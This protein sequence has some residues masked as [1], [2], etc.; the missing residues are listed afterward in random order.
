MTVTIARKSVPLDKD[1]LQVLEAL[2]QPGSDEA[3][4]LIDLTGAPLGSQSSEAQRLHA[5]IAAGRKAMQDKALEIAFE[6]Q[7]A[8][9][10]DHPDC[11]EWRRVMQGRHMRPFMDGQTEAGAA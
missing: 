11:Q 4:A 5:L 1:D 8:F 9:E 7:A 2:A 10:K 6:R 3:L